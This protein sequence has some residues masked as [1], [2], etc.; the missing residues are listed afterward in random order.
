MALGATLLTLVLALTGY[1]ESTGSAVVAQPGA[2]VVGI[3]VALQPAA[4]RRSCCSASCRS[5]A[6][7]CGGATSRRM[8]RR[9]GRAHDRVPPGSGRHP[10]RAR[11]A[12]RRR[13]ADAR[14]A[15]AL[16]RLRL[17]RGRARRARRGGGA[18]RAAR[19][20]ARPDHVHLGRRDG[21][22]ASWAS[23]AGCSMATA[24]RA[25][26]S[27][28]VTSGGTESCLLAVKTARD[29]WRAA[30]VGTP[31]VPR[32]VAPVTVHAA[33]H[34]A[35]EYFG[36][37]LD[38]VPVDPATG[39]HDPGGDRGAAR[40]RRR[41]RRGE[42]ALVPVR[43][44]R[45]RRRRRR[46]SARRAASRCTSTRASAGS[47]SPFWPDELPAWDFAVPGVTSLSADLHKYGYAPKGVSVL[48]TRGRDRQRAP[49]L[50]HDRAG[51]GTPSST[52]R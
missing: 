49:V 30:R 1:A 39:T 32:L 44:P 24:T 2:A 45:S 41:A 33:F 9:G 25:T 8:P 12:A 23:R 10:R 15:R 29:V 40:R 35:A 43:D 14:R 19:E 28:S 50:R 7:R 5:G 21:V 11:G 34:K 27:G 18:A 37:E 17:G 46:A 47:R 48:L 42:R 38:L 26:W 31:R 16:V 6:T 20:R 52:R 36:L 22:A 51:P 3:V 4:R 13:R